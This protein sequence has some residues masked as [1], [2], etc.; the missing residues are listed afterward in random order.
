MQIFIIIGVSGIGIDN[1][2][3]AGRTSSLLVDYM[4]LRSKNSGLELIT[5]SVSLCTNG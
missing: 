5:R 3:T 4:E 1:R 2:F